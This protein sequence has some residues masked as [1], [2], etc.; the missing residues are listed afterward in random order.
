MSK[1]IERKSEA[2]LVAKEVYRTKEK[3]YSDANVL[4][5]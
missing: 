4:V 2:Y 1:A 5:K 3:R